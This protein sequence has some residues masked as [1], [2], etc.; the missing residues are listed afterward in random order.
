M[1]K[2]RDVGV[3]LCFVVLLLARPAVAGD[4]A[5]DL[6]G[7]LSISTFDQIPELKAEL[8][9][10]PLDMF[11]S[12][13]AELYKTGQS[14][15]EGAPLL[16]GMVLEAYSRRLAEAEIADKV[17]MIVSDTNAPAALKRDLLRDVRRWTEAADI[18]STLD[19]LS[20][21]GAPGEDTW[22][23]AQYAASR[24]LRSAYSKATRQPSELQN[25]DKIQN[26]SKA[27]MKRVIHHLVKHCSGEEVFEKWTAKILANY[28]QITPQD[29]DDALVETLS[30]ADVTISRQIAILD[31][32]CVWTEKSKGVCEYVGKLRDKAD[33]EGTPLA[34][35]DAERVERLLKQQ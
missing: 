24:L 5:K 21:I 20:N 15:E 28:R 35:Q 1:K 31:V 17:L 10:F 26:M 16:T 2:T 32:T 33:R 8:A 12:L 14:S 7:R 3:I 19:K 30:G 6:A 29:L 23:Y 4:A 18:E 22:L 11:P 25:V 27:R 34:G 9:K 13:F